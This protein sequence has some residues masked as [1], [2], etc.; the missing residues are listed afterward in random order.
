M[1]LALQGKNPCPEL[2]SDDPYSLGWDWVTGDGSRHREYCSGDE[3][4]ELIRSSESMKF[5]RDESVFS[6]VDQEIVWTE[7][8][9]AK[10]R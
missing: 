9:P 8:I 5:N 1:G 10:G 6:S 3:M 2:S 4:T 7:R